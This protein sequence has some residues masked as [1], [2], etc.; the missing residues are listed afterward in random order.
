MNAL[1]EEEN[2]MKADHRRQLED[3]QRA[4]YDY[5]NKIKEDKKVIDERNR[6]EM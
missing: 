5:M 1:N 2:R 6:I 3:Q 4:H